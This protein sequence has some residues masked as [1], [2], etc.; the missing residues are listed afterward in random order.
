MENIVNTFYK[1]NINKFGFGGWNTTKNNMKEILSSYPYPSNM[2]R[3]IDKYFQK[4]IVRPED[5]NKNIHKN[6]VPSI[7]SKILP[8]KERVDFS[9]VNAQEIKPISISQYKNFDNHGFMNTQPK[10][11]PTENFSPALIRMEL[12]ERKMSELE[13][14]TRLEMKKSLNEMNDKYIDPRFKHFLDNN[15]GKYDV[16]GNDPDPLDERRNFVK[17]KL[18]N[19]KNQLDNNENED[20]KKKKKMRIKKKKMNKKKKKKRNYFDDVEEIQEKNEDEEKEVS[21]LSPEKENINTIDSPLK[22]IQNINNLPKRNSITGTPRHKTS[23]MASPKKLSNKSSL[24]NNLAIKNKT[25]RS[26]SMSIMNKTSAKNSKK[27]SKKVSVKGSIIG[28]RRASIKGSVHGSKRGSVRGTVINSPT[29][30]GNTK[31]ISSKNLKDDIQND[32]AGKV[33]GDIGY[34][35]EGKTNKEKVLQ[36]QTNRIGKEFDKL[37]QEM[38]EFKRTIKTKMSVQHSDETI[39][40]NILK[41]I[42]LLDNRAI[43]K[44]AVDKAI[45]KVNEPFDIEKYKKKVEK[46]KLEEIDKLIDKK[47]GD[48]ND[49]VK[50]LGY[51]KHIWDEKQQMM[52]NNIINKYE[53][54]KYREKVNNKITTLPNIFIKASKLMMDKTDDVIAQKDKKD[55]RNRMK[56]LI[57]KT[58]NTSTKSSENRI[59]VYNNIREETI[60]FGDT[61]NDDSDL[62]SKEK[63]EISK[64]PQIKNT[65][66]NKDNMKEKTEDWVSFK[67]EEKKDDL[68]NEENKTN[69]KKTESKKESNKTKEDNEEKENEEKENEENENDENEEKEEDEENENEEKEENKNEEKE[70]N[71]NEEKEEDEKNENEEKEENENEEKEE[72]EGEED[73]ENEDDEEESEEENRDEEDDDDNDEEESEE[74]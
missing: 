5:K 11:V 47:L 8:P 64:L 12:L 51:D 9:E 60:H 20:Y 70:E 41:D 13:N 48:Y 59:S 34:S 45:N 32:D 67:E 35:F 21:V 36:F 55:K 40:L 23:T 33:L 7:Y 6:Y 66:E 73:S 14:K 31:R 69:S 27:G 46:E 38:N 25:T 18:G 39:K 42:F 61:V 50:K 26:P 68:N 63:S 71:E 56:T 3:Q 72:D 28:T 44:Y 43:M 19:I 17:N 2:G 24:V 57:N 54:R 10:V 1:G 29:M 16:F 62:N 58:Y 30:K 4:G 22:L 15:Q 53:Y 65:E 52:H 49:N 74:K 37:L